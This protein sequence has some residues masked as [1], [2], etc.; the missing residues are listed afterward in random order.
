MPQKTCLIHRMVSLQIIWCLHPSNACRVC[1]LYPGSCLG[2]LLTL[3][4]QIYFGVLFFCFHKEWREA[5]RDRGRYIYTEE[6]ACPKTEFWQ[7]SIVLE[8]VEHVHG[9]RNIGSRRRGKKL[10][11]A[12]GKQSCVDEGGYWELLG[13]SNLSAQS[14]YFPLVSCPPAFLLLCWLTLVQIYDFHP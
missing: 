12:S 10:P 7:H 9:D 4:N 1:T 14:S 6:S 2:G 8:M 13:T 11:W 3:A 5:E